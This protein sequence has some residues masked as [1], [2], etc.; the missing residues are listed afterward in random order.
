MN[1]DAGYVLFMKS[2][3]I[4]GSIQKRISIQNLQISNDLPIFQAQ[5]LIIQVLNHRF[6]IIQVL[7]HR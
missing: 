7:N 3:D 6:L 4:S 1:I 2:L 5:I